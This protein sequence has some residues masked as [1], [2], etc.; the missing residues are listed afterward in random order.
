MS[1]AVAL[2]PTADDPFLTPDRLWIFGRGGHARVVLDCADQSELAIGFVDLAAETPWFLGYPLVTETT[3]L[4][5]AQGL[6]Q[7]PRVILALGNNHIRA[8]ARA[9]LRTLGMAT[10]AAQVQAAT[11]FVS[12]RAMLG[13]G[14][15]VLPGAVVNSGAQLGLDVIV[16]SGAVVEHDAQV[17]DH[18]HIAPNATLTGDA[19]VGA[20]CFIGAGAVVRNRAK[21]GDDVTVGAGAVVVQHL[22]VP[23]IY[24]GAPARPISSNSRS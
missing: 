3:W 6:T 17:G 24:V 12:S 7:P 16:N 19:Q 4:E 5:R 8:R 15:M 11:A 2:P 22:T 20:R 13:P 23:G 9:R 18:S 21:V 1:I 10:T 14:A